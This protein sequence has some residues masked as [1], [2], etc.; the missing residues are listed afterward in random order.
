M[1]APKVIVRISSNEAGSCRVCGTYVDG[2][3]DFEAACN[4]VLEHGLKCLHVGQ[5]TILGADGGP[6]QTTVAI[7]GPQ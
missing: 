7:F 1:F 2:T 6:W 3:K 4:H 5:E